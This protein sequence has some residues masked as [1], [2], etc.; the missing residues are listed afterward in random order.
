MIAIDK[1]DSMRPG[2]AIIVVGGGNFAISIAETN[3]IHDFVV[4]VDLHFY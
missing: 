3:Q 4:V 1:E 2:R